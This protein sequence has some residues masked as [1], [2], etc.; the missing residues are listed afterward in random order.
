VQEGNRRVE[1]ISKLQ[2]E[3]AERIKNIEKGLIK[4]EEKPKCNKA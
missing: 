3:M 2:A 1:Q 4:G